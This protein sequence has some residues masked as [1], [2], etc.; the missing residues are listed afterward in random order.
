PVITV[1][2]LDGYAGHGLGFGRVAPPVCDFPRPVKQIG[3]PGTS[4]GC[5]NPDPGAAGGKR[6][7]EC[8]DLSAEHAVQILDPATVPCVGIG[9]PDPVTTTLGVHGASSLN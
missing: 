9:P 5:G 2:P 7:G 8:L 4:P 3:P 6:V 1:I